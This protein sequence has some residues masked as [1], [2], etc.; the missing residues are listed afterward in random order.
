MR[1]HCLK[2]IAKPTDV[3]C[4]AMLRIMLSPNNTGYGGEV[5][6]AIARGNSVGDVSGVTDI[7]PLVIQAPQVKA[8]DQV[9]V[10][11][12][13]LSNNTTNQSF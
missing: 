9:A 8:F 10:S 11:G 3:R 2:N 12:Q 7:T 13:V 4:P 5:Q 6:H 1:L